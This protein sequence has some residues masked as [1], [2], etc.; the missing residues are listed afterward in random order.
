MSKYE[1]QITIAVHWITKDSYATGDAGTV[2]ITRL[3][4]KKLKDVTLTSGTLDA[5]SAAYP[6]DLGS[7]DMTLAEVK[8]QVA[9]RLKMLAYKQKPIV[10]KPSIADDP[11]ELKADVRYF[12]DFQGNCFHGATLFSAGEGGQGVPRMSVE[13]SVQVGPAK[14]PV[15]GELA[16]FFRYKKLP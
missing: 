4:A 7:K 6:V 15:R 8:R 5:W 10:F 1:C 9:E 12:Y 11:V 13:G 16:A 14:R 3:L 2:E